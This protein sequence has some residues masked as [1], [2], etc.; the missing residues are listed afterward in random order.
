M[1]PYIEIDVVPRQDF[2][3]SH[4]SLSTS[5]APPRR[6]GSVKREDDAS[7]PT[8][9]N[10]NTPKG[11]HG[12]DGASSSRYS[13]PSTASSRESFEPWRQR[14]R[15]RRQRRQ[16]GEETTDEDEVEPRLRINGQS[17]TSVSSVKPPEG[18]RPDSYLSELCPS[19]ADDSWCSAQRLGPITSR[20]RVACEWVFK[21]DVSNPIICRK[22]FLTVDAL[23][24][25]VVESHCRPFLAEGK[26][27]CHWDKC[28]RYRSYTRAQFED[29]FFQQHLA[30]HAY[31][32]PFQDCRRGTSC[33]DK[34]SQ[35]EHIDFY[36][37]VGDALRPFVAPILILEAM[38][39]LASLPPLPT[40]P[41]SRYKL[42]P[43]I[44]KTKMPFIP[45]ARPRQVESSLVGPAAPAQLG[46]VQPWVE[47][48]DRCESM[49]P[50]AIPV[51]LGP[52][53][54]IIGTAATIDLD[55]FAKT[56]LTFSA[57][58]DFMIDDE[59]DKRTSIAAAVEATLPTSATPRKRV[60]FVPPS[61]RQGQMV[62][63]SSAESTPVSRSA[64]KPASRD[65]SA[66]SL[67]DD[68]ENH[69]IDGRQY[70]EEGESKTHSSSGRL[71]QSSG[72]SDE[73]E[74]VTLP[75]PPGL[76]DNENSPK[77]PRKKKRRLA[78][79]E[80]DTEDEGKDGR[81][82]TLNSKENSHSSLAVERQMSLSPASSRSAS[83]EP[84]QVSSFRPLT[85]P[86]AQEAREIG[87]LRQSFSRLSQEVHEDAQRRRS[88]KA[89]KDK[90]KELDRRKRKKAR[91]EEA[92]GS[93]DEEP[94]Q[95]SLDGWNHGS[96]T[97]KKP[98]GNA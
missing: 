93:E 31:A 58:D 20:G 61:F 96:N 37:S 10:N 25:H 15:R 39:S 22:K 41:V 19:Y 27:Q 43:Q 83:S 74:Y 60:P 67:D 17:S 49:E 30:Q 89:V 95:V 48:I 97:A 69:P 50:P 44:P 14:R 86:T 42:D 68:E 26:W 9:I 87:S 21:T 11:V 29:H 94:A 18:P 46:V 72:S 79:D 24:R 80:S 75:G 98:Q 38:P 6:Q 35:A 40:M 36:H 85:R 66:Y 59:Q 70:V 55:Q 56:A 47:V 57:D 84:L 28:S 33:R 73:L 1:E 45:R 52:N 76:M 77:A 91:N 4:S 23:A 2:V 71:R 62:A 12:D 65:M 78:I 8:P 16:D 64:S 54:R 92:D 53:R 34:E 63:K 90:T 51:V 5:Q 82:V 81:Q 7:A 3:L 88:S 13:S 32:C